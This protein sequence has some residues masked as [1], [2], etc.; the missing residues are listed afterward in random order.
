VRFK[1]GQWLTLMIS[2]IDSK[3][4]EGWVEI[5]G[6]KGTYLMDGSHSKI[7][8]H[9]TG[10]IITL[11]FKNPPDEWQRYYDHV[12]DHLVKGKPL[13]ITA[14]WS[15]RPIHILDLGVRSARLGRSLPVQHA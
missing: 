7:Y 3:A 11:Q 1:S 14:E 2:S 8:S 5:T 15:R 10:D 12:R 13:V 4:K 9:V 6:T